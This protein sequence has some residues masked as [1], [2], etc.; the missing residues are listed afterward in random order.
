MARGLAI[1]DED[2]LEQ[3]VRLHQVLHHFTQESS[4]KDDLLFKGG[5]CFV[6]CHL[7][8][9]RFS[10][11]LD[12]TWRSGDA[13]IKASIRKVRDLTRPARGAWRDA[14]AQAA[15]RLDY[16]FDPGAITWGSRSRMGTA[17]FRFTNLRGEPGSIKLMS[18]VPG[19]GVCG[20][21]GRTH[22]ADGLDA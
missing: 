11:D 15:T 13:W 5:T 7:D 6:K 10:V 20:T 21:P 17:Q 22:A 3:D 2:R 14:L 18:A 4:I 8:N 12:F 1:Q 16:R 19:R 9:Q